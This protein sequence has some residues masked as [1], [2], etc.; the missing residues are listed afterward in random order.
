MKEKRS[1]LQPKNTSNPHT[2]AF[3]SKSHVR[4]SKTM[5]PDVDT[6]KPNIPPGSPFNLLSSELYLWGV[7]LPP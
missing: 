1:Q 6:T 5:P 7:T 2:L 4:R 3:S